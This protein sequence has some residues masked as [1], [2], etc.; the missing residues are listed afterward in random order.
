HSAEQ[1]SSSE[2]QYPQQRRILPVLP[3]DTHHIGSDQSLLI[4]GESGQEPQPDNPP[5]LSPFT[6]RQTSLLASSN[7]RLTSRTRVQIKV[8]DFCNNRYTNCIV[9]FVLAASR[10][11]IIASVVDYLQ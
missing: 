4:D 5:T 9:I 6:S 7:D 3:L 1:I 2:N 10:S 11:R 8:K